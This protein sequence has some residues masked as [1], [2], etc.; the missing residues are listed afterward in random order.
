[1]NLF[2][3]C[4]TKNSQSR[5]IFEFLQS[6]TWCTTKKLNVLMNISNLIS[7]LNVFI[8][9]RRRALNHLMTDSRNK[10]RR[11]KNFI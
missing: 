1:L 4:F 10:Y 2:R 8:R 11:E 7:V 3:K 5:H 9:E 6:K